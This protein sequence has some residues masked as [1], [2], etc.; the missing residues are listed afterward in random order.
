MKNNNKVTAYDIAQM[1]D[2][3]LLRP[4]LTRQD[5]VK[6]CRL[7][8]EYECATVCVKPCD[9]VVAAEELKD[10]NVKVTTVVGF[11]HG[12]NMT[13][14]K[15]FEAAL[16]IEQGCE[17]LD[18][19]INI[20]RL[21]SGDYELVENDVK[22]VCELAAKHNVKVKVIFENF[23]LTDNEKKTACQICTRA[24]AGWVKTATGFAG[25]GA[26][27]EDLQLMRANTPD[28]IQV[29]AAGGVRTLDAALTVRKIGCTRFGAT[30]TVAIIEEARKRE[31]EG[32][33]RLPDDIMPLVKK[34]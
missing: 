11:P 34:Y 1:I 6:G 27:I 22:S 14:T 30:A 23:Y 7:A 17:E 12:S 10:S 32:S 29:K 19:V 24:G 20:D 2:H 33:L 9:V 5:I 28:H 15:V 21:K 18:M 31:A 4:E 25:G 3:S 16:A 26:T 8:H 13:A